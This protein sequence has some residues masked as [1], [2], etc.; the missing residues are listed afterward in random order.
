M[1]Y[2]C[3]IH[4]LPPAEDF[5]ADFFLF[6]P[7][8]T[9]KCFRIVWMDISGPEV[10]HLIIWPSSKITVHSLKIIGL[11]FVVAINECDNFSFGFFESCIDSDDEYEPYYL[12]R[13]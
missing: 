6:G 12:E 3:T 10:E 8:S 4:Y 2:K 5:M 7:K 11:V 13:V 1:E 9:P